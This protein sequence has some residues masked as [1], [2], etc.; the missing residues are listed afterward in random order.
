VND[1]TTRLRVSFE[2]FPPK[3]ADG[4]DQLGDTVQRLRAADPAFVSVTYGAGGTSRDR[5]FAAIE[6]VRRAGVDVAAH[7]T[8]VGQSV[9]DVLAVVDRFERL[10]V[11]QI[12]ALRGDP[13]GGVDAAYAPHDDGFHRTADLVAA[14]ADRFD[15]SVS[16]YPERHPQS[17]TLAHDL[18]VL[19][20]KVAAGATQAMTQM[21]FDNATF[22]AYRDA[23]AAR[24][25]DVTL[26]PGIFPIHSFSA[27][28]S[29][30]AR[31]GATIPAALA[32]RFAG[33]DD[34]SAAREVAADVAAE[35]IAELAA[36]GVEHVH[37]Y[38][39]NRAELALGVCERLGAV[40]A[41]SVA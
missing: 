33:V 2:V 19:A 30:A 1:T 40:A 10:G 27:V 22:F 32:D 4:L 36:N 3:T 18:D 41:E 34:P 15:V 11:D 21:F 25:I 38:T 9:A 24:G 13:P 28:S 31:C 8:C 26:V 14:V 29:F 17:P 16:A 39:L 35:Q 12:V 37:V 20:G 7:L 5:S 23:V 6:T